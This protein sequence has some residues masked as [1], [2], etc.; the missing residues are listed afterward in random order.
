MNVTDDY[1]LYLNER[2]EGITKL[3]NAQFINVHERLEE[4]KVQTTKS[5]QRISKIEA[6]EAE[7]KDLEIEVRD[8]VVSHKE[9][10]PAMGKIEDIKEELS[11]YRLFKKYPKVGLVLLSVAVILIVMSG[12]Q[13]VEKTSAGRQAVEQTRELLESNAK[14]I[15]ELRSQGGSVY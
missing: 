11:E 2:F 15:E 5:N 8:L 3:M 9:T 14:L 1:R 4:I 10:C 6:R 12:Y 13:I 7:I